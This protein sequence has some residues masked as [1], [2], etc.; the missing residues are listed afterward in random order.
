LIVQAI[1]AL[2]A[3]SSPPLSDDLRAHLKAARDLHVRQPLGRVQ[4][5]LRALHIAIWQRQLRG[6]PLQR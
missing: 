5:D 3:K 6:S 2:F 1:Q 4:H